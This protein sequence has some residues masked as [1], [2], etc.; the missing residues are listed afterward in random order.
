[1]KKSTILMAALVCAFSAS[2]QYTV[3][4]EVKKVLEAGTPTTVYPV[5]LDKQSVQTFADAGS[6]IIELNADDNTRHFYW[7]NE[8]GWT[9]GE[10]S[11]PGVGMHFDGYVSLNIT[12]QGGWSGGGFAM[13]LPGVDI[14]G[15]SENTRFH[16]AYRTATKAPASMAVILVDA[17][18]PAKVAVGDAFDDNGQVF[19]TIGPAF[20]DDWQGIDISFA[21]LKKTYP[22]FD[23]TAVEKDRTLNAWT[24][25][26]LSILT[27]AVAGTNVCLD[28][29]YFY[30]P[31]TTGVE[32]VSNDSDM[33][34]IT[35][36]TV[37]A[38]GE[39]QV[40]D[41]NGRMVK[42]RINTVG[43]DGM[44]QGVYMVRNGKN[45]RKVVKR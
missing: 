44:Q 12:G 19:P 18:K 45:V 17:G 25:N 4:P 8:A 39:I 24:G 9:A 34:V 22:S 11:Y 40:Y 7:W 28:A 10:D 5:V 32:G 2:A 16:M 27:G 3:D 41:T 36:N 42:S 30:N 37:N 20:T 43:L 31:T 35:G 6:N 26:I 21:D 23:W 29:V 15:F 33:M 13:G 1:M 38:R 14:S